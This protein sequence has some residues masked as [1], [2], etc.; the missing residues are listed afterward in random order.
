[1]LA[2]RL[3]GLSV[4]RLVVLT[5]FLAL[6]ALIYLRGV[7]GT[8]SSTVA[9][10]VVVVG[11]F[12]AALYAALLRREKLLPA[13]GYAQIVTDQLLW[14]VIV[15]LTGGAA[16]GAVSLYGLSTVGAAILHGARGATV[17][18]LTAAAA[19]VG[20]VSLLILG[21]IPLPPD[22]Q[23]D[24][25]ART[26][27]GAAYPVV[28]NLLALLVVAA[29]CGYLAERLRITGGDL[30]RAEER[31]KQAERLAG[32]GRLAAGLAHEIRNP[33][34][35]ISG[36][37]ELLRTSPQLN[38][39]DRALCDIVQREA[40]RLNDLVGDMLN[41]ARPQQPAIA[42]VDAAQIAIEVVALAAK[43]GRG[44]DV[45]VVYEG[46][47][48]LELAADAAQLRQVLW[49]LIRNAVQASSPGDEVKVEL[50]DDA[51]QVQLRVVDHGPGIPPESADKIFDAFYTTRS[52]GTG[53]GLAVVKHIIDAHGWEISVKSAE[54]DGPARTPSTPMVH[55]PGAAFTVLIPRRT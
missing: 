6:I 45:A 5:I 50:L 49:N 26:L 54:E 35:G 31:A 51:S 30:V 12:L 55:P 42:K 52:Q 23:A 41:L 22:Q 19:Y 32:L 18:F 53:V 15:Y 34:G 47:S 7:T 2:R 27:D 36:S 46:P 20:M 29:M 10:A 40:E 4:V 44:E 48:N 1:M 3:V 28:S 21:R 43:S 9:F 38:D 16:S 11:Y 33:L 25:F 13:V 8:F 39:E 17:G 24:A 37:I 14:T